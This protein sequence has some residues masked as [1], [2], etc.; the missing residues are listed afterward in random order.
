MGICSNCSSGDFAEDTAQG[1][2]YCTT[3]GMVQE[4][5]AIVAS[6]NFNTEGPKATLNGQIVGLDSRNVG[7]GFVDSSYYIKNTIS[8][9]CA[10]LGLGIDHVECSFRWYKLLLQYNLSKGKSILYTLSACI[11]IVCRQEK[12]PHMLMD[13]SNALHID[14]FKIGKSFLKI[15]SMLGIDIPL[16]DPSLYMPRFVS[17]LRFESS[18]VLGLSLRLISRMKRDWIVVGR[19]PNN[20]CGAALLIASRI[21]GEERSIYEIAKIV[22]VS[23][24]TINKRLKEIG[25][26]ESAN[27]SIEEFNAT[28]IDKEEDPPSVKVRRMEM[29]KKQECESG[30]NE[31]VPY[32]TPQSSID[33]DVLSDSEEIERNILSPEETKRREIVWEE[34]YGEFMR[35]REK[36][37]KSS[38]KK[39]KRRRRNE[40]FGSIVEAFRSLDR[41]ISGKLN[42]QAIESIFDKL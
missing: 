23:V 40:E 14:V 11:Y 33:S 16:I 13:F 4:E 41:R 36:R 22:H 29:A 12:T 2:V 24:S 34:M 5:N 37:V 42:Y 25:D 26:T 8:G 30:S 3:C 9:I 35:E 38:V 6:L 32:S 7:T 10:S 19:R 28:W 17:R 15:T 1:A 21:V 39:G 27:L 20:L 31:T 18:E